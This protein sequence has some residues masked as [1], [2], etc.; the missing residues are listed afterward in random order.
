MIDEEDMFDEEKG[1][2][3]ELKEYDSNVLQRSVKIVE[4][5]LKETNDI[6]R[7]N[8]YK[9]ILS[10]AM[11]YLCRRYNRF[12][13]RKQISLY[14]AGR[15]FGGNEVSSR[16]YAKKIYE[17]MKSKGL[18]ELPLEEMEYDY[19][20]RAW[21]INEMKEA[22]ADKEKEEREEYYRLKAKYDD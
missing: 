15:L 7:C 4:M 22:I 19:I 10:G 11:E 12:P 2:L 13:G 8:S 17:F 6:I 3:E 20:D 9:N 21:Y 5:Y 1:I 16:T 14:R 18:H